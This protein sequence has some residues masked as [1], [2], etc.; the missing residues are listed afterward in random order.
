[1]G[2]ASPSAPSPA[3]LTLHSLL[4]DALGLGD[5]A[6]TNQSAGGGT[7]V[8]N[9]AE[10]LLEQLSSLLSSN[11]SQSDSDDPNADLSRDDLRTLMATVAS[12]VWS[13]PLRGGNQTTLSG[14]DISVTLISVDSAREGETVTFE[15]ADGTEVL[16]GLPGSFFA[17][18]NASRNSSLVGVVGVVLYGGATAQAVSVMGE[19]GE[20]GEGDDGGQLMSVVVDVMI[21]DGGGGVPSRRS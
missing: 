15:A 10:E 3:G 19:G 21:A 14:G 2:L 20:G 16:V 9:A 5:G 13:D 11:S 12:V 8:Q 4:E 17:G 6:P 18:W 7:H 1:M